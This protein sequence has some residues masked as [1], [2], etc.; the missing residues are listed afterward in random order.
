VSYA[1]QEASVQDA[2]PVLL[3]QF[4]Q[5]VTTY[6]YCNLAAAITRSGQSWLPAVIVPGNFSHAGDIPKDPLSLRLPRD[7][8]L[9]ATFLGYA[10][11]VITTLT[12]FRTNYDDTEVVTYWKGRVAH[13]SAT[14]DI[15]TLTCES[16]YAALRRMGL[17]PVYQRPCRRALY[18]P[19][20]N[21]V[22]EDHD[23]VELCSAV[24]GAVVTI[25]GGS[26]LADLTGGTLLYDGTERM[27][28]VHDGDTITL[29]QPIKALILALVANPGGV[30]VTLYDGCDHT[31]DTCR[32]VFNNLGNYG[33]FLGIPDRNPMR[34]NV[35]FDL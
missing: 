29:M 32:D 17:Y 28:L 27:I 24:A 18:G 15:V 1:G 21:V 4:I 26:E 8:A 10:P 31:A 11:D 22:R 14:G 3:F 30:N 20:C 33:G 13:G 9:A 6:R 5:G 25:P 2:M 19:G 23:H 34:G 35:V 16:L 12:V 7:N